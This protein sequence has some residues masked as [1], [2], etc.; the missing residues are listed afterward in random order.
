MAQRTIHY[1]F[2]EILSR[3]VQLKDKNRFLLGSILPDAYADVA[4]R[5][6][7]HYKVKWENKS[8]LD[9]EAFREEYL[10]FICR[11][12]LYLG[13][14]MHLVEDAFYRQ[15][16]YNEHK[17]M[18]R[19]KDGVIRL[20]Q[21]Y[22]ILNSYIVQKYGLKNELHMENDMEVET[23]HKI[24]DFRIEAFLEEMSKDFQEDIVGE[25]YYITEVMADEFIEK[26]VPI[27]EEELKSI[28]K[29]ISTLCAKDFIWEKN[30]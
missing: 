3:H 6:K 30:R 29:G 5:D 24:A 18:P 21:D 22:H 17:K 26:Y 28:Q 20:H 1:L 8:F 10:D 25:T 2:G 19:G 7:T 13:Y 9:F 11:D 15:V 12:D 16:F 4:D 23:F 14:Y 27:A